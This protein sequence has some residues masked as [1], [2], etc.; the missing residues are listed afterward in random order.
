MPV[1]V[2]ESPA[3]AKTVG[4]YLGRN[5]NVIASFGHVRDLAEKD[6][7]VD[8]SQD[9]R[10]KWEVPAAAR[11]HIQDIAGA[12]QSD[13][14]L[15]L[16]TD[17]DRE[18]EAISWHIREVLRRRRGLKLSGEPKR[19]VFNAVTESAVRKAMREPRGIDME[20][21]DAYLARRALDYLV[22]YTLS[23]VLWRKLPGARSAGRVQSVCVR[24]IVEREM[25]IESFSA[26]EYWSVTANFVTPSGEE[27]EAKL[28]HLGGTRLR[29]FDLADEQAASRAAQAISDREFAVDSIDKKPVFSNPPPPFMTSTLQQDANRR[30][31][32][33]PRRTMQAAQRLYEAGLI[34]Y[35]RTDGVDMTPE[36]VQGAR[37]EIDRRFGASF[38]PKQPNRYKTRAKNAQEAHECIRPTEMGRDA[39][40]LRGVMAD[41]HRL[42][43]LI[44][45]R[46]IA[47]QM[48][49]A[50]FLQTTAD[51]L[52]TDGEV[53][54]RASGRVTE[55]KGFTV[56]YGDSRD[57]NGKR[58][59]DDS[60]SSGG[61]N[62][63]LPE[64]NNGDC[65]A[66]KNVTPLQHF[67]KPPPRYSEAGLVK[68]MVDLGIGRP[69]TYSSIVSTI[70]DRGYVSRKSGRLVP[71]P[72]GRLLTVFLK[73]YFQKYVGFE[74]TAGLEEELDDVSGGR[75]DRR[76]VL[77]RFW[78]EFAAA[79]AS[80]SELRIGD[81]LDRLSDAI[82]PTLLPARQDGTDIRLCPR[83]GRGRLNL[84]ASRNGAFIGCSA[85]PECRFMLSLDGGEGD[86][87]PS[88]LGADPET[89]LEVTLN[90][91]RFGPYLQL[92]PFERG[93]EKP[94]R[95]TVP[96]EFEPGTVNL[97]MAL[98]LLSL[99]RTVGS[100]PDD[101]APVEAGIGRYGPFVRHGKKY[102]R[103]ANTAEALEVGMN[104]AVDL[105]SKGPSRGRA[106]STPLKE[107]GEHPDGGAVNVMDGR[108]G[109]YVTWNKTNATLPKSMEPS[110]VSLA[111]AIELINKKKFARNRKT[112]NRR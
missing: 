89:G 95:V 99:P 41:E 67:T 57:E 17:P 35:M 59:D 112:R 30:F 48:N 49:P 61:S 111:D 107:L 45:N 39:G 90:S 102:A 72:S 101:G 47:C 7:S 105:L 77:D 15:I 82:V 106:P 31:G 21:V 63:R 81:V 46:A 23:P 109:P 12:L 52:S 42:Y 37:R 36:A 60:D 3:K 75:K 84:R 8:P 91:G 55:F 43:E 71:E 44:W 32:M 14:D 83:C 85:Y 64:L 103:L 108:Y 79:V 24:I 76:D 93:Q 69:S 22:G 94:K 53:G 87:G 16:A 96:K 27:F 51:I 104:R 6:G 92:G 66:G 4:K 1:V 50:R 33:S 70:Q 11:K 5:Y 19:V 25:E 26:K 98:A 20:L 9:F 40:S 74:F 88:S 18:G 56:V 2:V 100:H 65:V 110:S 73:L 68:K 58:S 86:S 34:T 62:S 54:L 80:A 13:N 78:H 28:A 97:E 10:M 38:L 29:R